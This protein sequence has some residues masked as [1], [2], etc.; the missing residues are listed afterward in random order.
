MLNEIVKNMI[1]NLAALTAKQII[2]GSIVLCTLVASLFSNT[3]LKKSEPEKASV[4]NSTNKNENVNSNINYNNV[5]ITEKPALTDDSPVS[6][7]IYKVD[8]EVV[9]SNLNIHG[10]DIKDL[11]ELVKGT[12]DQPGLHKMMTFLYKQKKEEL[13]QQELKQRE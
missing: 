2:V 1:S 10:S 6:Y 7:G 11:K 5:N 8:M 9:K 13:K 12:K 3:V 4:E